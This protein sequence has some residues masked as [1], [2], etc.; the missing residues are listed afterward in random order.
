MTGFHGTRF[1]S[2]RE[3]QNWSRAH[4]TETEDLVYKS[5][6]SQRVA[7]FQSFLDDLDDDL[8]IS[9][10]RLRAPCCTDKFRL[11]AKKGSAF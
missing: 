2:S 5:K 6:P 1:D 3:D 8:F 9:T 7:A 11:R 10:L 4:A